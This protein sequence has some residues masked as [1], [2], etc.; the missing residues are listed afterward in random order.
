VSPSGFFPP[1]PSDEATV[2]ATPTNGLR[3][4]TVVAETRRALLHATDR[5]ALLAE[6][7]RVAVEVAGLRMAWI[8]LLD[9]DGEVRVAA[10]AGAVGAY[11]DGIR[12]VPG[13]PT[14]GAG[15]TGQSVRSRRPIISDD[16]AADPSMAPWRDRALAHGFG[17]SG[18]IPIVAGD[19]VLGALSVYAG[20][21]GYFEPE[22][23][24]AL[25]SLCLDI[26]V[27]LERLDLI[28]DLEA[29]RAELRRDLTQQQHLADELR[30]VDNMKDV[31]LS[32]ISHELRTPLT[33]VQGFA[34]TLLAKHQE[35]DAELQAELLGRL[36]DNADR[37]AD[38]IDDLLAIDR[39]ARGVLE[40]IRRPL[41]LSELVE[42][43]IGAIP[44]TAD[45]VTVAG[46][47]VHAELDGAM[48]QRIIENLVV[49]ALR[50]TP[51]GTRVVVA[52]S[53]EA[54]AVVLV[55]EDDGPGI[56]APLRSEV[57]EPFRQGA[58]APVR[59]AGIGLAVVRHFAE[60]HG[61]DVT[62]EDADRGGTRV[63]VRIPHQ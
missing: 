58:A 47:I 9:P 48:V 56:P 59:G 26:G 5:K 2:T 12:I 20:Q 41:C 61:G 35:I 60:L 29:A 3:P 39:I 43:V 1:D 36:A 57:L 19:A 37:L 63:V 40:P 42:A 54:D 18:A 11:L 15:P 46:E 52:T 30:R 49:N 16:I 34:R 17:A 33:S 23:V 50:H 51:E 44:G 38:L 8:G 7:C 25:T 24:E 62:V 28:S 13:D 6:A 45:R 21:V 27:A 14:F 55:V 4:L 53:D 10:S 22:I 32:A 31:F